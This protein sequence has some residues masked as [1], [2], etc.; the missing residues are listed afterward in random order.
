MY[1]VKLEENGLLNIYQE[2]RFFDLAKCFVC[3]C[4]LKKFWI[5]DGTIFFQSK[6]LFFKY[7]SHCFFFF[8]S[9]C[10]LHKVVIYSYYFLYWEV[11]HVLRHSI[12][13]L[14]KKGDIVRFFKFYSGICT[15]KVKQK[16]YFWITNCNRNASSI[17]L[18]FAL[19]SVLRILGEYPRA[20]KIESI[21]RSK[22]VNR[23][24]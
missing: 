11:T 17:F 4:L 23:H 22:I 20:F 1:D 19:T 3:F 24:D 6:S 10:K 5:D 12:F 21:H 18:D 16:K 8:Y 2:N 13:H 15:L 14:S 7:F 9:Y